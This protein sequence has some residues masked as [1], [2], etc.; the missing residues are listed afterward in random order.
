MNARTKQVALCLA[1]LAIGGL[2]SWYYTEYRPTLATPTDQQMP[3]PT[4]NVSPRPDSPNP[5]PT[6]LQTRRI[7]IT[8]EAGRVSIV[9]TTNDRG[10]PVAIIRDGTKA[11]TIDLAWLAR[12]AE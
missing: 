11:R 4:P 2:S 1:C 10:V 6:I 8:D 7:E 5:T 3:A 12:K 9:L